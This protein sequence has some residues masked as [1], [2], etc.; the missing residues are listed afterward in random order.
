MSNRPIGVN[1]YL[2]ALELEA[3]QKANVFLAD[4]A[5]RPSR[6]Q[7]DIEQARYGM[8]ELFKKIDAARQAQSRKAGIRSGLRFKG[9]KDADYGQNQGTN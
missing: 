2:S 8:D 3:L 9:Q 4:L 5:D 6:T 7:A 1:I